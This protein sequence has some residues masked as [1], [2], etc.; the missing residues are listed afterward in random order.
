MSSRRLLVIALVATLM[1]AAATVALAGTRRVRT[2]CGPAR[3][4]TLAHSSVA[5]IYAR[6]AW[7]YGCVAP[8]GRP[9][10]L[11]ATSAALGV[12]PGTA[13][14]TQAC[15]AG[16]VA[17]YAL[18]RSGIDTGSTEVIARG[19]GSG[20]L[21][22]EDPALSAPV[23]VE[24]FDDVDALVCRAD[25]ALAWIGSGAS[26]QHPSTKLEVA[27]HARGVLRIL[28]TAPTISEHSL[29]LSGSTLRWR[30]GQAR[31]SAPLF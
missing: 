27:E 11:G 16:K 6:G 17:A 28:D 23:G 5:R 4:R 10:R 15:V 2:I 20:R 31:R 25:G 8:A 19:L 12:A 7:V 13:T 14:V 22:S 30:D 9:V 26:I 1:G 29:R 24:G 18:S 21:L 3:A